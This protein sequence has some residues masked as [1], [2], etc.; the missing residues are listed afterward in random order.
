MATCG[1]RKS[2]TH[3]PVKAEKQFEGDQADDVPFQ[4]QAALVVH[5]FDEGAGGLADQRELSLHRATALH[6]LVFVLQ[7]RIKTLEPGM[8]SQ[9]VGFFLDLDASDHAV[10]GQQDIADLP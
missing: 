5:E 4:A 3:Q 1:E 7:S 6:Q 10:L 9:N 2:A 8:V